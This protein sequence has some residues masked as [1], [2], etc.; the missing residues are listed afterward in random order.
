MAK[1]LEQILGYVTH[2]GIV[3]NPNGGLPNVWPEQCFKLTTPIEGDKAELIETPNTRTS[4]RANNRGAASRREEGVGLTQRYTKAISVFSHMDHA[5]EILDSI[6][7]FDNPQAQARGEQILALQTS[8][9]RR[10]LL[11][12]RV[13]ALNSIFRYGQIYLGADG[14]ILASSSGAVQTIEFQVPANN[15]NQLNSAISAGW[16]TAGTNILGDLTTIN[17]RAVQATGLP[18]KY[19][20]YG[21][22]IP[23]YFA[24]N[25]G[26]AA[27]MQSNRLL[28]ESLAMNKIPEGFGIEGLTWRPLHTSFHEAADGTQTAWFPS[29]FI[30]FMPEVT[31][32][33]YEL[34]EG[35]RLIPT[36]VDAA[37]DAAAAASNLTPARGMFS[38]AKVMSDPITVRHW[39][40]D[41]FLP[42]LRNPSA[43]F[44]A[45]TVA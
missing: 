23:G 19:A 10:K 17:L 30:V 27:L 43:V 44:L 2:T 39:M 8:E 20:Y 14:D 11:N 13:N 40:G 7:Q 12:L 21:S 41:T 38:Y 36:S 24:A 42:C 29:D 16:S 6:R 18:L 45:D 31:R 35:T 34:Q 28:T 9:F 3:N 1:T 25:T 33:W 15:K 37:Q 22:A 32:D 4:A 26:I 5:T